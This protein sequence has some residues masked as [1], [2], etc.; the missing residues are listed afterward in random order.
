MHSPLFHPSHSDLR[1][2]VS[3]GS[4]IYSVIYPVDYR[5][6]LGEPVT[7]RAKNQLDTI[8]PFTI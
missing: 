6:F 3:A 1:Q 4:K 5:I 8:S 7:P 2:G